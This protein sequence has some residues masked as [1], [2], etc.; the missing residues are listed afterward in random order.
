MVVCVVGIAGTDGMK[1]F[2]EQHECTKV[3]LVCPCNG[4]NSSGLFMYLRVLSEMLAL[5]CGSM[6][7]GSSVCLILANSFSISIETRN[8]SYFS[9]MKW[10][11]PQCMT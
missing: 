4:N 6:K 1:C 5:S 10:H 2:W 9:T 3:I 7:V 8:K 11:I